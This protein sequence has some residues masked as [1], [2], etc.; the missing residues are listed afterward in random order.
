MAIVST[1]NRPF[2]FGQSDKREFI[3]YNSE[4]EIRCEN[5]ANGNAIYIGFAKVGSAE[6]DPVWRLSMNAYDANNSL[7]SQKW[8]ENASAIPTT[9]YEF[10]WTG[11]AG[12]TFS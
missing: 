1:E 9:N 11:H 5:D 10:K 2:K 8:A 4:L 12:Y 3:T 6:G 7:L